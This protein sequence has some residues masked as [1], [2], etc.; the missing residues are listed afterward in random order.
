MRRGHV[1]PGGVWPP[2]MGV[3][4]RKLSELDQYVAELVNFDDGGNYLP[5]S[6]IIVGGK[7]MVLNVACDLQGGVITKPGYGGRLPRIELTDQVPVFGVPRTRSV[8]LSFLACEGNG[9]QPIFFDRNG[10]CLGTSQISLSGVNL[11]ML[12]TGRALHEG[13]TLVRVTCS[14]RY[15]GPKPTVTKT[16]AFYLQ[17]LDR[18]TGALSSLHT[19]GTVG[20]TVYFTSYFARRNY[21]TVEDYFSEGNVVSVVYE[22]NQNNVIDK[23]TYNYGFGL[24][25]SIPTQ[26]IGVKFEYSISE[27]RFE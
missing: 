4:S 23:A 24:T 12:V 1:M 5:S 26:P 2:L 17:R 11:G 25:T 19:N 18:T 13:A 22:P 10:V 20:S 8:S 16:E 9:A 21:A 14:F 3:P 27:Q 7:G 15:S 6:P